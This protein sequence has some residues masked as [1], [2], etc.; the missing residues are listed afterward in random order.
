MRGGKHGP[1]R[2]GKH[3]QPLSRDVTGKKRKNGGGPF[4]QPLRET[5]CSKG[6]TIG[7]VVVQNWLKSFQ[8]IYLVGTGNYYPDGRGCL[9]DFSLLWT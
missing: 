7:D 6:E 5:L 3:S 1:R 8:R 4:G 9:C 2:I